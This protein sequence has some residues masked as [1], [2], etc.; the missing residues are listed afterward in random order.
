MGVPE[1]ITPNNMVHCG[2][3]ETYKLYRQHVHIFL[4]FHIRY[5]EVRLLRG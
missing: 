4:V 3:Y 2:T 5:H 1:S